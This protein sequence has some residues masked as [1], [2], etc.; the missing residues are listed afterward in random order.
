M[1]KHTNVPT[2]SNEPHPQDHPKS[3]AILYHAVLDL[4]HDDLKHTRE[5]YDEVGSWQQL[6][7]TGSS[8]TPWAQIK[9]LG[10]LGNLSCVDYAFW[11]EISWESKHLSSR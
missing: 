2:L 8:V 10:H 6:R 9:V 11:D 5:Y 3:A 7:R 4:Y 1:H